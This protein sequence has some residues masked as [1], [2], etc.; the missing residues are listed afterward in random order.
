MGAA[1]RIPFEQGAGE[2]PLIEEEHLSTSSQTL[3]NLEGLT[4]KV[5]TL[6]LQAEEEEEKEVAEQLW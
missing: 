1:E 2:T 6:G 3:E 5:G 4:E